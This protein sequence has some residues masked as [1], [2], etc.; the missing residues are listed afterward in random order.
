LYLLI[1]TRSRV[2]PLRYLLPQREFVPDFGGVGG[3][4][5]I[6]NDVVLIEEEAFF[7]DLD[8]VAVG[9]EGVGVKGDGVEGPEFVPLGEDFDGVGVGI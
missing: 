7:G 1:Q 8:F 3:N 5:G 2:S 6:G 4:G 9:S